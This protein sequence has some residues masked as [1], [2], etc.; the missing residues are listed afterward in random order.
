MPMNKYAEIVVFVVLERKVRFGVSKG[1][2]KCIGLMCKMQQSKIPTISFE[3]PLNSGV[4]LSAQVSPNRLDY[5]FN[6]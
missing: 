6:Y 3:I 5:A 1:A 4:N 2:S